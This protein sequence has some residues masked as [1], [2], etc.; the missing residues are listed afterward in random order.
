MTCDVANIMWRQW[1]VYVGENV[2]SG[3]ASRQRE[4][5]RSNGKGTAV[6]FYHVT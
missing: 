4:I 3:V 1:L 2:A 5:F 6:A